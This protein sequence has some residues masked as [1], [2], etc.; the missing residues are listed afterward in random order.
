MTPGGFPYQASAEGEVVWWEVLRVSDSY[1]IEEADVS[2]NDIFTARTQKCTLPNLPPCL[3]MEE[4]QTLTEMS[5][6]VH[7]PKGGQKVGHM[8]V[9]GVL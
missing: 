4:P 9:P 5:E 2:P 7:Q 8:L 1:V 6:E 3:S